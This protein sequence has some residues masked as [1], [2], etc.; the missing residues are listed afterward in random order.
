MRKE[1]IETNGPSS[2]LQVK[3]EYS[4]ASDS[5]LDTDSNF[6][7]ESLVNSQIDAELNSENEDNS[8]KILGVVAQSRFNY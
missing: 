3:S 8:T 1:G 6:D 5:A 7:S 4:N 2:F